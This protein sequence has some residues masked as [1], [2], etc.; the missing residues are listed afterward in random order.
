MPVERSVCGCTPKFSGGPSGP[1]AATNC[2]VAALLDPPKWR[3]T[4]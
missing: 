1:S 4:S 2:Q 3:R